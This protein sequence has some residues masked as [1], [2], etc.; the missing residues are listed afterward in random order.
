MGK[1]I[2]NFRPSIAAISRAWLGL[3]LSQETKDAL[4]PD[5]ERF[6]LGAEDFHA[7]F[8]KLKI[9]L[10]E[11]GVDAPDIISYCTAWKS[12]LME[13]MAAFDKYIEILAYVAPPVEPPIEPELPEAQWEMGQNYVLDERTGVSNSSSEPDA[14]LLGMDRNST[15]SRNREP[16]IEMGDVIQVQS[17]EY[18]MM[19]RASRSWACTPGPATVLR[20]MGGPVT[21]LPKEG[22]GDKAFYIEFGGRLHFLGT[23]SAPHF[24]KNA[25]TAL[26]KSETRYSARWNPEDAELINFDDV[27]VF[28]GV[29]DGGFD[30]RTDQGFKT[31][32]GVHTYGISYWRLLDCV[33]ENIH[34]EHGNYHQYVQ[35]PL[36]DQ[37]PLNY[38]L[39]MERCTGRELGRTFLQ[40]KNRPFDENGR[41]MPDATGKVI[42]AR[43]EAID[44][45]LND[46]GSAFTISGHGGP[47]FLE[48]CSVSLGNDPSMPD[49]P[50]TGKSTPLNQRVAGALV[51]NQAK[52]DNY[53]E[54]TWR[55]GR[56][57]YITDF[58]ATI[59][60]VWPG[61][62]SWRRP[63]FE[64]KYQD[65][66]WIDGLEITMGEGTREALD[67][68]LDQ[69]AS[70]GAT[71]ELIINASEPVRGDILVSGKSYKD[72]LRNGA[73]W[74][75]MVS[76]IR[77]MSNVTIR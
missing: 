47:V 66:V 5:Q 76:D 77:G 67:W 61:Q 35:P 28:W 70:D 45:G 20:T 68:D 46:A 37:G 19:H 50:G 14:D 42:I 44:V 12:F 10:G 16:L 48:M 6:M 1:K 57:V 4:K 27:L 36:E 64:M 51:L 58:K 15:S 18:P 55:R 69:K 56:E 74:D 71:R 38:G 63:A 49:I 33:I 52:N 8:E 41:E 43:C 31:K 39:L 75:A 17:G 24:F 3:G 65:L 2:A 13:S 25:T 62:G 54:S 53:P 72:P 7:E 23:P 22:S 26:L 32:W 34:G 60:T 30:F 11:E 21:W 9:L 29:F 73:A 40:L 59:G